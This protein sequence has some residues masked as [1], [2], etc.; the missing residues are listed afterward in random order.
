MILVDPAFTHAKTPSIFKKSHS[1][2][3]AD[4]AM[5]VTSGFVV[6]D[7]QANKLGQ[8]NAAIVK[9][10][11]NAYWTM[12]G[13]VSPLWQPSAFKGVS[14]ESTGKLSL[15]VTGDENTM[16][17]AVDVD[18]WACEYAFAHS[19]RLF[20]K[21]LTKEQ[22]IDRY[23][24]IVRKADKYPAFIKFKIGQDRN[25]PSY[26]DTER[27]KRDQ[28]ED[29]TCCQLNCRLRVV[30]MWFQST[31]FGLSVQLSDAQVSTE[32]MQICPF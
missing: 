7:V 22:V 1:M 2:S 27:N 8:K 17:Q 28:P 6:L 4:A 11:Q 23:C 26:W 18:A 16:G 30:G 20:G 14:G 13:P 12:A 10:G 29:F 15:C 31:S 21:Q 32:A 24:P 9:D 25:A 5:A 3:I 19:E